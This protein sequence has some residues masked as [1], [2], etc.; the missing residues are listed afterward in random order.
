[1]VINRS[2]SDWKYATN[3][4]LQGSVLVPLLFVVYINDLPDAIKSQ[5]YNMFVDDTN[6]YRLISDGSEIGILQAN[7]D[8]QQDWSEKMTPKYKSMEL[9][10]SSAFT[11][12]K[13][14]QKKRLGCYSVP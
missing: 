11:K 6:M 14:R 5:I 1:M 2:A 3:G 13:S 7:L 8:C 4:I 12:H 9:G 10:K